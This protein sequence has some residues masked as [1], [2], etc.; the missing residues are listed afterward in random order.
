M[1]NNSYGGGGFSQSFL[2]A[3]GGLN[4][5]SILFVASAG[6][7]APAQPNPTTKSFPIIPRATLPPNVIGVAN[8]D[9]SDNLSGSSH[10]GLTTVHLGAPGSGILS[11]TPGNNYGFLTGTSMATPHV[12]GAA[13]LLL[14]QNPNLTLQ[15]LKSLLIFNGD[16]A[17][18][19]IEQDGDR[20]TPEC[21]Q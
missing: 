19:F 2:D 17:A 4:Q 15:Q 10:F 8:T 16:P 3:I 11:T 9:S 14:A 20:P 13:A 18:A 6:N 21:L 12:S 5:S 7:I 1:L